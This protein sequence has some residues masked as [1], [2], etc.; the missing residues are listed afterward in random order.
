[1][2]NFRIAVKS[3]IVHNNGVLLLKRRS[4]DVHKP[5]IWDIPGGRLGLGEDPYEGIR[6]ETKEETNLDIDISM[7]LDVHHFTRDDGQKITML[8]FL[9]QAKDQDIKLSEEH[10]EFK[11]HALADK[12]EMPEWLHSVVGNYEKFV[13]K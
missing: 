7:P 13:K 5:G 1:M 9:C 11:W 6:R 3:F 2:D 12:D 10:S 8:I 4:T